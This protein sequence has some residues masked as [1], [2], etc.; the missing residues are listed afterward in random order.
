MMSRSLKEVV[1]TLCRLLSHLGIEDVPSPELF[2]R[3]KFNR[4]DTTPDFWRLLFS[5]LKN[6]T[7]S[8]TLPSETELDA[9]VHF[10]KSALWHSGY[11][12]PELY[13][14]P[15]DGS[16]GSRELLLALSWLFHKIDLLEL[17]LL[18][19]AR[20]TAGDETTLDEQ[21]YHSLAHPFCPEE[22]SNDS[23]MTGQLDKDIRHL[24]WLQG[25]LCFQWR[26]LLASQEEMAALL[27]KIHAYTGGCHSDTSLSHLS[28]K[29]IRLI[30][31]PEELSVM[32]K[33]L[34]ADMVLLESYLEWKQLEPLYWQWMESVLDAKVTELSCPENV[35]NND[36]AFNIINNM[37][38]GNL[39]AGSKTGQMFKEPGAVK[40]KGASLKTLM[41][42][43]KQLGLP[44]ELN[45]FDSS[46]KSLHKVGQTPSLLIRPRCQIVPT[47]ACRLVLRE[48]NK[49][50][51]K[52][53]PE[54][55]HSVKVLASDVIKGLKEKEAILSSQLMK[56]KN[57]C[58]M[59]IQT[60]MEKIEGV[61]FL[62]PMKNIDSK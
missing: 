35:E 16:E 9:K 46:R 50:T 6:I 59:N 58:K 20:C 22:N 14:L 51:A 38:S 57:D 28:L 19:Q 62:P 37:D 18:S 53:P 3:A 45:T 30:K 7:P 1:L 47:M 11:G 33:Q 25:Q 10:V 43:K 2:R 61:I 24:Q 34:D 23:V 5:V 44:E 12:A 40:E 32:S 39:A 52:P 56:L 29:E 60:R 15:G 8:V 41:I 21:C 17:L 42:K 26:I 55:V 4:A 48:E 49:K 27:Y 36:V 31:D 54:R 13:W